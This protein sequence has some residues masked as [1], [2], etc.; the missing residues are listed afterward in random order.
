MA[1]DDFI[2]TLDSEEES[3]PDPIRP[4][5]RSSPKQADEALLDPAFT[6]DMSG[7]PYTDLIHGGADYADLVK[8]GSR[9]VRSIRCFVLF[10]EYSLDRTQYP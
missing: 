9:P 10:A 1:P 8:S 3:P 4:S 7:D 6:F 5:K 2:M